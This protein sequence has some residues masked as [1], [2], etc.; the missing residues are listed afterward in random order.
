MLKE[1][2]SRGILLIAYLRGGVVVSGTIKCNE[3]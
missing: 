1:L 3:Y 2:T